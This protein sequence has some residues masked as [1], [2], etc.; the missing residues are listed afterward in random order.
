MVKNRRMHNAEAGTETR[1]ASLKVSL[2]KPNHFF[3]SWEFN[4][5]SLTNS[6]NFPSLDSAGVAHITISREGDTYL[7][8]TEPTASIL[9]PSPA[10]KKYHFRVSSEVLSTQSQYFRG[11]FSH[12]WKD[13]ELREG[14]YYICLQSLPAPALYMLLIALHNPFTYNP[15][16]DS[17]SG[18]PQL[19]NTLPIEV[20]VDIML[21]ADFLDLSTFQCQFSPGTVWRWFQPFWNA[22]GSWDLP[23]YYDYEIMMWW[24]LAKYFGP[25]DADGCSLLEAAERIIIYSPA[26]LQDFD[27]PVAY[28]NMEYLKQ[29]REWF[30]W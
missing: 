8:L 16:Q 17:Y 1:R 23:S 20:L 10:P 21:C 19:P 22:E 11:L 24:C 7:T 27:L 9:N 18:G 26:E 29:Q 14:K 2:Q 30:S 5:T 12:P 25:T 4:M 3:T 6:L 15:E 13:R 28:A